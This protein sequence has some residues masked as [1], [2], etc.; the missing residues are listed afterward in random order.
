MPRVGNASAPGEAPEAKGGQLAAIHA[1]QMQHA[2]AMAKQTDAMGSL[3]AE[4]G[5][6]RS[7]MKTLLKGMEGNGDPPKA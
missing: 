2:E 3:M 6:L 1:V 4:V 5:E 7:M